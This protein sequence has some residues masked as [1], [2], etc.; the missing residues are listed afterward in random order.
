MTE[1]PNAA[2][3]FASSPGNPTGTSTNE[4]IGKIKAAWKG[5][6]GV[7]IASFIIAAVVILFILFFILMIVFTSQKSTVNDQL[8]KVEKDFK[9]CQSDKSSCQS[10][11]EQCK[12]DNEGKENEIRNQRSNLEKLNKEL[13]EVK[14]QVEQKKK[15]LD[16]CNTENSNCKNNVEAMQRQLSECQNTVRELNNHVED[17][18][19]Q[20]A[21]KIAEHAKLAQE[22]FYFQMTA[23]A[24]GVVHVGVLI[25]DIYAHVAGSNCQTNLTNCT[26]NFLVCNKTLADCHIEYGVCKKKI[27]ELDKQLKDCGGEVQ[28]CKSGYARCIEETHKAKDE[29][30]V[31]HQEIEK[32][33]LM[34]VEQAMLHELLKEAKYSYSSILR[35]NG[36]EVGYSK[37]NF[38]ARMTGLNSDTSVVIVRTK[39]GLV[40]GG[41]LGIKWAGN[42]GWKADPK[43][44]IFAGTPYKECIVDAQRAIN[45][46]AEYIEFGGEFVIKP[47]AGKTTSGYYKCNSAGGDKEEFEVVDLLAYEVFLTKSS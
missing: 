39:N 4:G 34:A 36:T 29:N 8:L 20:I 3:L 11:L 37:N 1:A 47:S 12:K 25:E 28:K 31:L 5:S 24:S 14:K 40:F 13:T 43:A 7:K 44:F 10:G 15:E 45:F 17:L 19:K 46:D 33:P 23:V 18:K 27:E 22:L 35:F 32:M 21:A 16:I 42:G 41:F 6:L 26:Q 9:L 38:I 2:D 30:A